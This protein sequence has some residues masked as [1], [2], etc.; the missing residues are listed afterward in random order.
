MPVQLLGVDFHKYRTRGR[1]QN[2]QQRNVE[3][4]ALDTT[5]LEKLLLDISK[6]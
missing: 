3:A 1:L 2:N 5:I 4:S 6:S